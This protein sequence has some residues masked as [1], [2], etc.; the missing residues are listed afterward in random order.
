MMS[1][2]LPS[3][4]DGEAKRAVLKFVTN[5]TT[6]GGSFIDPANRIAV[7][8]N[9]G[10]LWAEQPIPVQFDFIIRALEDAAHRDVTL[11]EQQPY[12]AILARDL[13]Y[14][15]AVVNEQQPDAVMALEQALARTW[16]GILLMNSRPRSQSI[17]V[18]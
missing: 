4:N 10:T 14:L 15:E 9:D 1:D 5:S 8:D 7:F 16:L 11:A 12:R 2:P 17:Y 6:A 3:W 18:T 13:S